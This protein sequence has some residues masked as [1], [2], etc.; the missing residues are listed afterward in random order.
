MTGEL[1]RSFHPRAEAG[2]PNERIAILGA[3]IS[4]L[5]LGWLL[6]RQGRQVTLFEASNQTGGL[7]RTFE[8]HGLPC[9]LA[10]HRLHT[11]DKRILSEIQ[12]LVP[13]RKF[14]R[15]SRILMRGK[16]IRDPINPLELL[17]RFA[18]RV[19]LSLA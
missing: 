14:E 18:P 12:R 19:G 3:G 17:V 13:L 4:G 10:P 6:S 5:S 2:A 16:Q 15:R 11:N 7:A 9:D 1:Q 8:W